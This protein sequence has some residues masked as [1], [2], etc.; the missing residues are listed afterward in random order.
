MVDT[1]KIE[2][3][4]GRTEQDPETGDELP[5]LD[6]VFESKGRLQI[7]SVLSAAERDAGGAQMVTSRM[8][9]HLPWDCDQ[10]KPGL[11]ATCTATGAGS[12]A[13]MVGMKVRIVGPTNK[14]YA[15]ATRLIVE[16]TS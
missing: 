16:E 11:Y 12:D 9:L 13:R 3:D 10:V 6:P 2:E 14:T 8:E 7:R 15:T 1:W 5:V 4:T